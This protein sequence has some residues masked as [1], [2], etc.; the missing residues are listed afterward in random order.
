MRRI[1][2]TDNDGDAFYAIMASYLL[3][4]MDKF[5]RYTQKPDINIKEDGA[6]IAGLQIFASKDELTEL[7]RK[8][9]EIW[10][11]YM[12]RTD[13][14]QRMHVVSLV[15]TPPEQEEREDSE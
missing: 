7:H 10:R 2:E 4:M 8:T 13:D 5:K 12:E 6:C 14:G 11:P 15:V 3:V 9:Y 1:V